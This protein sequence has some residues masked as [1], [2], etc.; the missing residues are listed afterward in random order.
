MGQKWCPVSSPGLRPLGK[1]DT[2]SLTSPPAPPPH[3]QNHW[4][5]M[6]LW[7]AAGSRSGRGAGTVWGPGRPARVELRLSGTT[8]ATVY[9]RRADSGVPGTHGGER[10][11]FLHLGHHVCRWMSWKSWEWSRGCGPRA[12]SGLGLKGKERGGENSGWLLWDKSPRLAW[13][14][15]LG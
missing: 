12:D 6:E 10:H 5:G 15:S 1:V 4:A 13:A 2:G 8:D 11:K 3:T 14:G 7:E 9:H